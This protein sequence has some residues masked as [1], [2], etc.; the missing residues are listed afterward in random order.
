LITAGPI[1]DYNFALGNLTDMNFGGTA[2]KT[3]WHVLDNRV[4]SGDWHTMMWKQPEYKSAVKARY[5]ELR[6]GV[7]SDNGIVKLIDDV[8]KPIMNVAQRNFEA[9]PMGKCTSSG[10]F[11]GMGSSGT[12]KDTTWSG[13]VDSLKIW[14]KKRLKTLDSLMTT[15]Q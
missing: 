3:G 4:G 12:V 13:Q 5:M 1:W 9:W 2:K 10:G 8:R 6:G 7:L 11:M 14:T 15:I